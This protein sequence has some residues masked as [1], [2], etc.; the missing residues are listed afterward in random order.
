MDKERGSMDEK[1]T[2]KYYHFFSRYKLLHN[3]FSDT[4]SQPGNYYRCFEDSG[5]AILFYS[6]NF[7][8]QAA[9]YI[10]LDQAEGTPEL[11]ITLRKSFPIS[12]KVEI[13]HYHSDTLLGIVT[14]SRKIYD[15]EA[16]LRGRF[17]D[18]RS[19]KSQFG[20]S[21]VDAVGQ[22]IFGNV[23][24]SGGGLSRFGLI[25][26][27]EPAGYLDRRTL[28]FY[29]DSENEKKPK[30]VG[31]ALKRLLP[32]SLGKALFESSPPTG[33]ELGVTPSHL[34]DNPLLL[35][36]ATLMTIELNKL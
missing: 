1:A 24:A 26:D 29:P 21:A 32:D 33:W 28:P 18:S 19:F 35:L 13:R 17:A 5:D 27:G 2:M 25:L 34:P 9:G 36:A 31:T 23:E 14:K 30:R 11:K 6:H 8:K 10:F 3:T 20:E 16:K 4:Q 15:H 12:G 7:R 22:L